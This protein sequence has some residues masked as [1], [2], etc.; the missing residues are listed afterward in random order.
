MQNVM[1]P[2]FLLVLA[3]TLLSV[4]LV[5]VGLANRPTP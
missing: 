2:L 5:V 4:S 3:A 1:L